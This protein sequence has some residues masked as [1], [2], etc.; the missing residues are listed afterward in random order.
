MRMPTQWS[1]CLERSTTTVLWLT[2]LLTHS[3]RSLKLSG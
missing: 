2:V 1:F 3:V